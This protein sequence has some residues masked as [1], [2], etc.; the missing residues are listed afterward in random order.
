MIDPRI[1][2]IEFLS[3]LEQEKPTSLAYWD[4]EKRGVP[5]EH[6]NSMVF[7]L[8]CDDCLDGQS[9]VSIMA[10]GA[11]VFQLND[12]RRLSESMLAVQSILPRTGEFGFWFAWRGSTSTAVLA[13]TIASVAWRAR[14]GLNVL[15]LVITRAERSPVAPVPRSAAP[16]AALLFKK[17]AL[18]TS[19]N[20]ALAFSQGAPDRDVALASTARAETRETPRRGNAERSLLGVRPCQRST[21]E[22]ADWFRSSRDAFRREKLELSRRECARSAF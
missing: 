17:T 5:R 20:A 14:V 1:V 8:F 11:S 16:A 7:D 22:P 15:V 13:T 12:R 21:S 10:S 18:R 2:E 6:F 19:R 9:G 4:W 3:Y